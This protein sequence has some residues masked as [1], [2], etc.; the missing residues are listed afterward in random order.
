MPEKSTL[1]DGET[2]DKLLYW[3]S[4][5]HTRD[6]IKVWDRSYD[7]IKLGAV[8]TMSKKGD[9]VQTHV[10][11]KTGKGM[12]IGATVGVIGAVLTG[13]MSLLATAVGTGALGGVLG[14]FFKKS[15]HL[16]QKEIVAIGQELDAGRVA[17]VVNCDD[18]EVPLVT[19]YM[20]GSGGTV[21]TYN[22][23]SAALTEAANAPE[24]MDAVNEGSA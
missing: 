10:G 7:H 2:Y 5:Y 22:V 13:G 14:A 17:V 16:T 8:G 24:V 6:G 11:R 23:P 19:E 20:V 4:G 15:T 12:A 21:R 18:Y 9:K 3:L 1:C